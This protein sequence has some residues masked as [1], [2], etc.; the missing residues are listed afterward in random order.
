MTA[1][2]KAYM[3]NW[4]VANLFD[5]YFHPSLELGLSRDLKEVSVN[6]RRYCPPFQSGEEEE[7]L[8]S[9]LVNWRLTTV[10]GLQER[11]RAPEAAQHHA[12]LVEMLNE[13]MAGD[14]ALV[15]SDPAP[16]DLAGGISMIIELAVA[17]AQH[18]PME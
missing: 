6:V 16:P 2:G 5:M 3:S 18:M 1:V 10:D 13:K 17:V 4:L 12:R 8:T 11:L 15:L 9:K 14:M 7:A